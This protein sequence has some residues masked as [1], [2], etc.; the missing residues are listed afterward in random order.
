MLAVTDAAAKEMQSLL[1]KSGAPP[2]A[3]LRLVPETN[4][5]AFAVDVE[6]PGDQVIGHQGKTVLLIA[7]NIQPY[8]EGILLD[9]RD[10]PEGPRFAASRTEEAAAG[11]QPEGQEP[12]P[13]K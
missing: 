12:S 13:D 3:A 1:V 7:P 11:D 6:R 2:E 10:T 5:L 4:G 9:V 8:L